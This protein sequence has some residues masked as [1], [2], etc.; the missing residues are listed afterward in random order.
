MNLSKQNNLKFK[1]YQYSKSLNSVLIIL[2]SLNILSPPI[3]KPSYKIKIP[4]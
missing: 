1:R 2:L 3:K 4:L